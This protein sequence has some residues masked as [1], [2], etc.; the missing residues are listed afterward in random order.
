[1]RLTDLAD[2]LRS[3]GLVVVENPGWQARG[4]EFPGEPDTILCHHT[5]TPA[6]ASGDLPTL[7][8]LIEGRSDLPGPLCQ[9]ALS[10][11]GVVHVLAGGKANHAGKGAWKGQA[12][13]AHTIGIEAEH[14]GGT[15]PWPVNQYT[16]YIALCAALCRYLE[17][18]PDRVCAHREW[19]LP[20]GRKVDVTF[21]MD[22]FRTEVSK[23]LSS[24][25]PSDEDEMTPADWSKLD[26]MLNNK[27]R[28]ILRAEGTDGKPTGHPNLRDI[29]ARLDA[30]HAL[31]TKNEQTP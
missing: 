15:A 19:A 2:F 20:A 25:A 18:G 17:V 8:L 6:R 9:L 14:P 31:I 27:L 5:A 26:T 24:P 7:R 30:L 21:D 3:Q 12:S 11:T 29:E 28:I 4:V 23:R 22:H 13:S 1:M 10:R 16:A